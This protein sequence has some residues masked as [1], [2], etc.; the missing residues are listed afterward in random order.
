MRIDD[1]LRQIHERYW[2]EERQRAL[3]KTVIL[4]E[5]EDDRATLEVILDQTSGR[6]WRSRVHLTSA[7]GHAKVLEKG[8]LFPHPHRLIDRDVRSDQEVAELQLRYPFLL[9][10]DGWCLENVFL[11]HDFLG[12]RYPAVL[13]ELARVRARWVRAGAL[14]W[15]I[16]RAHERY[17]AWWDRV[18]STPYGRPRDD[19]DP[20]SAAEFSESFPVTPGAPVEV[21]ELARAFEARLRS[22]EAWPEREQWR[23]GVHGKEA[24]GQVLVPALEREFGGTKNW[25]MK[26]AQQV[27]RPAPLDG[28]FAVLGL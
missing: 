26:L 22:V 7:G 12:S 15:V 6:R 14:W 2:D 1:E 5:G 28:L 17:H 19:F 24:F 16:Q 13:P 23:L 25:R 3:Q 10:T 9:V 20:V 8:R 11:D 27:G 21:E 4:V 18:R